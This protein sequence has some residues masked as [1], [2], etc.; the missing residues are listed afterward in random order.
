[1]T[2]YRWVFEGWAAG[3]NQGL[4]DTEENAIEHRKEKKT[5]AK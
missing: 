2:A 5:F 1:V 3:P 4:I